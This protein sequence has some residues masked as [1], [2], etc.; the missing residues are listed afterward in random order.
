MVKPVA[1]GG[2]RKGVVK[3]AKSGSVSD[4]HPRGA[5][6][7]GAPRKNRR[8]SRRRASKSHA[9]ESHIRASSADD[10][11][12]Q[13]S[14][15]AQEVYVGKF[16]KI[17]DL[18]VCAR[19]HVALRLLL[20]SAGPDEAIMRSY[21]SCIN[22]LLFRERELHAKAAASGVATVDWPA[23]VDPDADDDDQVEA[24]KVASLVEHLSK[25]PEP[26]VELSELQKRLEALKVDGLVPV[27]PEVSVKP[28]PADRIRADRRIEL[29]GKRKVCR[30]INALDAEFA[31]AEDNIPAAPLLPATK[32]L[33]LPNVPKNTQAAEVKQLAKVTELK[34]RSV[35]KTEL[36][37]V[38]DQCAQ[39]SMVHL[40]PFE[41]VVPLSI[42]SKVSVLTWLVLIIGVVFFNHWID[43]DC[44]IGGLVPAPHSA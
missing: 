30:K 17:N 8:V 22:A 2:A 7:G 27:Q 21:V 38:K 5:P 33:V 32:E 20:E 34:A 29:K 43:I 3:G 10:Q 19:L 35:T 6:E 28:A 24:A 15:S 12:R 41:D 36:V 18:E 25:V 1:R 42:Q 11:L 26:D 14:P 4:Q 31:D 37:E 16:S 9:A 13:L 40:Q 39:A 44:E 23:V